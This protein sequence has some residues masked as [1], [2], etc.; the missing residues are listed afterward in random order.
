MVK[1]LVFLYVL[2]VCT[3]CVTQGAPLLEASPM[4]NATGPFP[5]TIQPTST[6]SPTLTTKPTLLAATPIPIFK[7][8]ID[9]L[10]IGRQGQLYASG[11]NEG[12]DLRHFAQWDGA[13]W[14]ELGDGFKTAGNSLAADGAGH[15]YSEVLTDTERCMGIM[16]WDGERW[17]DITA[18]FVEAVD[19]LQAGRVS[20]NIPVVALAVDGED[21]LYATGAFYYASADSG[22]ELPMGYVAMWNKETWTTLGHGFD[23]V[24]IYGLGVGATGKVYVF[25]EQPLI[26][27]GA[28]N[29]HGFIAEWDGEKW[30]PIDTSKLS[31]C[32]DVADIALDK[33]EGLYVAC[34][35]DGPGVVIGFWDGVDWTTITDQLEGEA[36]AV[37]DMAVDQNGQLCIGGAFD[38][39]SGVPA[40]FIA[41]WDGSSWRALGS[42][43]NE[44]VNALAFDPSGYLYAVGFFTQAGGQPADHA[45]RWDGEKWHALGQ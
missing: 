42:G 34:R 21:N 39:V 13:K 31:A 3:A 16:E 27:A 6:P 19:A 14:V 37:Y 17:E 29:T 30:T 15:L 32:L 38:S 1:S 45:A 20:C 12:D 2:L 28:Y 24:N 8:L 7:A 23:R 22:N 41:C 35:R 40:K 4:R 18:N 5:A 44:R 10:A 11:F 43:V 9:N 25:G 36:P 33:S 26:S